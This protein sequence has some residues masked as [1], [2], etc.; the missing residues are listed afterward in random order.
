M[1]FFEEFAGKKDERRKQKESSKEAEGEIYKG[2]NGAQRRDFDQSQER[3]GA[4][5]EREV[6]G[7]IAKNADLPQREIERTQVKHIKQL[8][9][10]H[11]DKGNGAGVV[12]IG[13]IKIKKSADR[14]Q[15]H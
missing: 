8:G 9:G 12:K 13:L 6:N 11:N 3:Q 14:K 2:E 5:A 10:D 4:D 1:G 7:V 15:G